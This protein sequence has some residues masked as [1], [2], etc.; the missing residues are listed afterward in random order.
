M[1]EP[2]FVARVLVVDDYKPFRR[3]LW[4]VLRKQPGLQVIDEASDGPEAIQKVRDLKPDLILLDIGLPRLNGI[5]TARYLSRF[6]PEVKV[7][8]I[9]QSAD[10]DVIQEALAGSAHGY[11]WKQTA[12]AELLPA[13]EAVLQGNRF[14]SSQLG[15]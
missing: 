11:I 13:V 9:S 4:E 8:F 15:G 1:P 14:V 7:L 3:F 6:H 2:D 5:E 10:P 12:N